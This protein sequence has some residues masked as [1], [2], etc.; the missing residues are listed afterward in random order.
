MGLFDRLRGKDKQQ[1]D[2]QPINEKAGLSENDRQTLMEALEKGTPCIPFIPIN[3]LRQSQTVLKEEGF[4]GFFIA[5]I[6]ALYEDGT[7]KYL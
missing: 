5:R 1:R 4:K 3:A 7:I 6:P 2:Q